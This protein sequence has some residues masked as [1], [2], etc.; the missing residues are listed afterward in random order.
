MSV[1]LRD[2]PG[3]MRL[4]AVPFKF[5]S[6]YSVSLPGS[7][8]STLGGRGIRL[9][10]VKVSSHFPSSGPVSVRIFEMAEQETLRERTATT[11]AILTKELGLGGP[12]GLLP[13]DQPDGSQ[14]GSLRHAW[15]NAGEDIAL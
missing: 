9:P 15:Y 12:S 7:K 10:L 4:Q 13:S 2:T 5:G 14:S 3:A 1:Y 11:A 6:G 8:S